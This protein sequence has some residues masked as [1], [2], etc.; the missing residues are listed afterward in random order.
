MTEEKTGT[1]EKMTADSVTFDIGESIYNF[2]KK[3]EE[4]DTTWNC[5][6]VFE[7]EDGTRIWG[8]TVLG[9]QL[10]PIQMYRKEQ[11]FTRNVFFAMCLWLCFLIPGIL[12]YFHKDNVKP[13]T[14]VLVIL[15]PPLGYWI[16][17][18]KLDRHF[19]IT[20]VAWPLGLYVGGWIWAYKHQ[21]C[22]VDSE[23]VKR[24]NT[25]NQ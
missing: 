17:M 5:K 6:K 11:E 25:Q 20:Q 18:R 2:D 8:D 21:P 22:E 3:Q 13:L 12:F 9:V 23:V 1:S 7:D 24:T 16:Q 10:P 14:N 4:K 19:Q 15:I